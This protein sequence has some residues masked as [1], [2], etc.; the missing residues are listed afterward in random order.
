MITE[1]FNN[2]GVSIGMTD[3]ISLVQGIGKHREINLINAP[4]KHISLE[5]KSIFISLH[6]SEGER[7]GYH[8]LVEWNTS[9]KEL[10]ERLGKEC[11]MIS[12][13]SLQRRKGCLILIKTHPGIKK[14]VIIKHLLQGKEVKGNDK[15]LVR[16]RLDK[17]LYFN[18]TG[19]YKCSMAGIAQGYSNIR[20]EV[21]KQFENNHFRYQ[22]RVKVNNPIVDYREEEVVRFYV[23]KMIPSRYYEK[24]LKELLDK[25]IYLNPDR[26]REECQEHLWN[27]NA[28]QPHR[29]NFATFSNHFD[30]WWN[31]SKLEKEYLQVPTIIQHIHFNENANL[32]KEVKRKIIAEI[33]GILKSI[34]TQEAIRKIRSEHPQMNKSQVEKICH[35]SINTIRRYW[36]KDIIQFEEELTR[37]NL[38]YA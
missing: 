9:K 31:K 20:E 37:I 2:K 27:I 16:L 29:M 34:K 4:D 33:V 10:V 6:S 14:E 5:N 36:E 28:G 35:Y 38:K 19:F 7:L 13:I 21:L 23:P 11:I 17:D 32:D 26:T 22:S 30:E 12:D 24:T 8:Y 25:M 1:L 15:E 3:I 18:P